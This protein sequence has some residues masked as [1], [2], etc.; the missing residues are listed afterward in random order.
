MTMRWDEGEDVKVLGW[1]KGRREGNSPLHLLLPP[2]LPPPLSSFFFS[3]S[4][5]P[6]PR[7]GNEVYVE[8]DLSHSLE[9]KRRGGGSRGMPNETERRRRRDD[10]LLFSAILQYPENAWEYHASTTSSKKYKED[11]DSAI[12]RVSLVKVDEGHGKQ[13]YSRMTTLNP[14]VFHFF[15]LTIQCRFCLISIVLV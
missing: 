11:Q 2:P 14:A 5:S 13:F 8:G 1:T 6:A 9:M 7:I 12:S 10:S 3:I 15:Q 4:I